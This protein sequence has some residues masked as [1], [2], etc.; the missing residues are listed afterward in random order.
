M[1]RQIVIYTDGSGDYR[2]KCGGWGA[3]IK[4]RSKEVE[5]SGSKSNTTT[6]RMEMMAAIKA[7][8]YI[9]RPTK[10][11]LFTDSQY[12]QRGASQY[13]YGW[14]RQ[15]WKAAKARDLKNLDLWRKLYKQI[16]RHKIQWV[17][18]PGHSGI[19]GNE[20]ADRLAHAAYKERRLKETGK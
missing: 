17:W 12:L 7:L 6:N 2:S 8:K 3:V 5:I 15:D 4:F 18:I 13:I 20:R 1:A 10:V 9:N 11:K 14:A 16:R 19:Q